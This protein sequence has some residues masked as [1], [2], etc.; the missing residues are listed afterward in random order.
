MVDLHGVEVPLA[1]W[2]DPRGAVSDLDASNRLLCFHC[3]TTRGRPSWRN[4][5]RAWSIVG[6][7]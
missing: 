3:A 1:A 5:Q 7:N 4:V 2:L 6:R